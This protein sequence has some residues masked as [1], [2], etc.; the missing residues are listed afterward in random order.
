MDGSM[1]GAAAVFLDRDGT[2][3]ED[4]GYLDHSS[5]V[6][7]YPWSVA[8]IRA[9]NLAGLRAVVTTNQ[10]GVAR[11]YFSESRVH[12]V[13]AHI[14]SVLAEGRARIDAYYYCP[15]HPDGTVEGYS[16]RCECR[17]PG[18]D[19]LAR[20]SRDLG[21][22]LHRSFVVGD[23]WLDVEMAANAGA[24]SVLVKTGVGAA[25]ASA[26]PEGLRAD[27]VADNL[28]AAVSW[29]LGKLRN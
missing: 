25:Q 21:I 26:P 1:S 3:I 14:T 12:E 11:G 15:H 23:R 9:L 13:H 5:R 29:I 17:K 4:V 19:M 8:A 18:I 22:D 2:M 16:Q 20:A 10:S 28:I 7:F 24:R 27:F 6:S